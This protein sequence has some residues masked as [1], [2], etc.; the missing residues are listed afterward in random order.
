MT[1]RIILLFVILTLLSL[2]TS[3]QIRKLA[4]EEAN[5]HQYDPD[6]DCLKCSFT[7]YFNSNRVCVRV[8]LGCAKWN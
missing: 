1:K 5:C 7:Y 4:Y 8:G 6:G 2:S 3:M